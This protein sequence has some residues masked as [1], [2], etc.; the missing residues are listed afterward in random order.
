LTSLTLAESTPCVLWISLIAERTEEMTLGTLCH[1][2]L[3][4]LTHRTRV[5]TGLVAML[6][7]HSAERT[8]RLTGTRH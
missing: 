6:A 7:E 8:E 4:A 5:V 2:S 1:G 3:V